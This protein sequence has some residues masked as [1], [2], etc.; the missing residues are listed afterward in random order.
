MPLILCISRN[1]HVKYLFLTFGLDLKSDKTKSQLPSKIAYCDYLAVFHVL[2]LAHLAVVLCD[3]YEL[4]VESEQHF[5]IS[6]NKYWI[7]TNITE[8]FRTRSE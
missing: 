7:K 8:I 5:F 4:A 6:K 3:H 1:G 2:S